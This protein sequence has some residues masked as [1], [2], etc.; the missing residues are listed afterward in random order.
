MTNAQGITMKFADRR[1]MYDQALN[2]AFGATKAPTLVGRA[3]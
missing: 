1:V 3:R 2:V